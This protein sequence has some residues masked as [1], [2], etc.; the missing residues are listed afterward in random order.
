[1]IPN[2][3]RCLSGIPRLLIYAWMYRETVSC[4]VISLLRSCDL[5]EDSVRVSPVWGALAAWLERMI[6]D[7]GVLCSNLGK[8]ASELLQ[9]RLSNFGIVFQ[10]RP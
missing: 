8:A 1:M 2:S 3:S 10:R 4:Y 7:R 9:F 6:G 5:L